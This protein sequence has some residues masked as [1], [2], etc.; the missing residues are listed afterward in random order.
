MVLASIALAAYRNARRTG[1]DLTA[2]YHHVDVAVRDHDRYGMI[3]AEIAELDS[4]VVDGEGQGGSCVVGSE[5]AL[6]LCRVGGQIAWA[7]SANAAAT[8]RAGGVSMASS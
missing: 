3:T 8:R 1:L 4:L 2:T 7:S 5:D 6:R